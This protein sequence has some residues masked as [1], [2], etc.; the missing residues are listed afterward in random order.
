MQLSEIMVDRVITVYAGATVKEAV[1]LMNKYGIGCLVVQEKMKPIG[2][3][4]ERDLMKRVLAKSKKPEEI[5]VRDVM[6]TPLVAGSRELEIE[7]ALRV[8]LE[9][10]I[11]KLPIIEKGSLIGIVSLTDLISS[12]PDVIGTVKE[13]AAKE[14][15]PKRIK[16]VA[17]YYVGLPTQP[18]LADYT[19]IKKLR[20]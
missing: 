15:T 6:S 7:S 5:I 10:G 12:Q 4:T 2:I 16:K 19:P 17:E 13:I 11:K 1:N 3:L 18:L 8:M 20:Q 9:R 14:Y